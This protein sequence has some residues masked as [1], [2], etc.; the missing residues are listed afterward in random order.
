M[1]GANAADLLRR[2]AA[3]FGARPALRSGDWVWTYAEYLA[4]SCRWANLLLDRRPSEGPFHVAVLMDNIPEYLFAFGGAALAGATIVGLNHTR[5]G[6][7][8][9]RDIRHTDCG[10]LI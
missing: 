8:L 9:L 4:E 7:H 6:P 5:R 1:P 3:E 2:N 10:I